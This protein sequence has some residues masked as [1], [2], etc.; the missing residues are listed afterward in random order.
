M[1]ETIIPSNNAKNI[2]HLTLSLTVYIIPIVVIIVTIE[3]N[4]ISC[5]ATTYIEFFFLIILKVLNM[6]RI[7]DITIPSVKNNKKENNSF[8]I[9]I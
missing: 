5:I 7:Q 6:S 2:Y 4:I 3:K 8:F 1:R 9:I